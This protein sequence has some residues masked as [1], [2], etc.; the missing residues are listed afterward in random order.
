MRGVGRFDQRGSI[1]DA[2]KQGA[3]TYGGGQLARQLGG[4][5]VQKDFLGTPGDRF[6]TPLSSDRMEGLRNLFRAREKTDVPVKKSQVKAGDWRKTCYIL[7]AHLFHQNNQ[8]LKT[9]GINGKECPQEC[10]QQLLVLVPVQ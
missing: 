3:L 6:T 1:S 7:I 4:A 5:G 9:F 10:E 8:Q 2:L